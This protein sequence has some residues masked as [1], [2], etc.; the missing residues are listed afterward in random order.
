MF[1]SFEAVAVLNGRKRLQ[2]NDCQRATIHTLEAKCSGKWSSDDPYGHSVNGGSDFSLYRCGACDSVCYLK[3]SWDSEGFDHD[4]QGNL[5]LLIDERQYQPASSANFVFNIQHTP[6]KL[7]GLIDETLYALAGGKL[8]LATVGLRLVIEFIVKDRKCAGNN[9]SSRITDLFTQDII[10]EPQ[11]DVLHKIRL[12]GNAG[13]HDG[14]S[15]TKREMIAGMAVVDLLLEKLYNAPQRQADAV[16]KATA[17]FG[18]TI[19]TDIFG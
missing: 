18:G 14:V 8:F 19:T 2:C 11:K 7:N 3:A 10:D 15:M 9:L 17:A 5:C 13:A 12:R 4:E 6:S 1:D 16:S